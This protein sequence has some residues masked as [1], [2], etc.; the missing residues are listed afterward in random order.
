[1]CSVNISV[2]LPLRRKVLLL[3]HLA[4][5]AVKRTM[6]VPR[7]HLLFVLASGLQG[8]RDHLLRLIIKLLSEFTV[9]PE[10]IVSGLDAFVA[11]VGNSNLRIARLLK[12]NLQVSVEVTII[13]VTGGLLGGDAHVRRLLLGT[14]RLLGNISQ[15]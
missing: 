7:S 6:L 3:G 13:L 8:R 5:V 11:G 12:L 15:V 2:D 10:T 4:V 14:W 9:D 1:M